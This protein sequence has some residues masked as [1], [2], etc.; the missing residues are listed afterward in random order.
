MN[1]LE[2]TIVTSIENGVKMIF[3]KKTEMLSV[4]FYCLTTKR[5]SLK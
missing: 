3:F 5:M 1:Q 2:L 4:F